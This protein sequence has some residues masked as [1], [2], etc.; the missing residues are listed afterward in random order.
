MIIFYRK[1]FSSWRMISLFFFLSSFFAP[2]HASLVPSSVMDSYLKG[3]SSE[4]MRQI[5]IDLK[6]IHEML[7][8]G[9]KTHKQYI[10]TA[11]GPGASKTTI[12]E[13]YLRED[14]ENI[15]HFVYVDPDQRGLK[16]MINTYLSDLSNYHISQNPSLQVLLKGAYGKWRGASNFIA[17]S[18]LNDAFS[19]SLSIAHGSTSTAPTMDSFYRSLKD[20]DYEITLLLCVSP[21]SNR[22]KAAKHR[23]DTQSFVQ[24]TE[25]DVI[26]KG[27]LFFERFPV[28]FKWADKIEFFWVDNFTTA[29]KKAAIYRRGKGLR[30]L[31]PQDFA[32]I[33]AIYQ[34]AQRLQSL[35]DFDKLVE[36]A[37]K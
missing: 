31:N 32:R 33:K 34:D 36:S 9:H 22:I 8:F 15:S 23:A 2:L 19:K 18:I 28:Y 26:Q 11:G 37:L 17:N 20:K 3:Y 10:A 5:Q 1:P 30:I 25:E 4:E 12:L 29:P 7:T 14:S 16:Y 35:E 24:S 21:D 6:N 27:K 13:T